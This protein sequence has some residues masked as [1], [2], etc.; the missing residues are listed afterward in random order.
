MVA[1][2]SNHQRLDDGAADSARPYAQRVLIETERL[3]LREL[4]MGDL[5]ELVAWHR[6][7]E[8][9]RFVRT[10]D[11]AQAEERL[12]AN[13]R[14]WR[15]RGHGMLAVIERDSK[16]LVGSSGLAGIRSSSRRR[17]PRGCCR[18]Q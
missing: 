9:A 10:L 17:W 11:R 18:S 4:V 15:E 2:W 13:E 6:D 1:A 7:R 16:R 8:V 3:L 12:R 14:E 5:E